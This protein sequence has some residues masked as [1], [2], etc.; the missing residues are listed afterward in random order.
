MSLMFVLRLIIEFLGVIVVEI[1][2]RF[3]P[4]REFIMLVLRL[5]LVSVVGELI[6]FES[7]KSTFLSTS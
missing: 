3:D 1:S 4:F 7:S 5:F 6:V 2:C